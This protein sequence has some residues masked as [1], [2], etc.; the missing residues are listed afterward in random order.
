MT[1]D[2]WWACHRDVWGDGWEP[3]AAAIRPSNSQHGRDVTI[4]PLHRRLDALRA[5]SFPDPASRGLRLRA[6]GTPVSDHDVSG[7]GW[8]SLGRLTQPITTMMPVWQHG[9]SLKD[10]PVSASKRSR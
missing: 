9:H 10:R 7:T 1:T 5:A 4:W 2:P 6:V 8:Q 3:F